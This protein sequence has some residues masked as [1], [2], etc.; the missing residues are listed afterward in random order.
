MA[1]LSKTRIILRDL[2]DGVSDENE[3][4]KDIHENTIKNSIIQLVIGIIVGGMLV[5][6]FV[7]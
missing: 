6:F 7:L 4:V 2:V 3:A 5:Y 1:K